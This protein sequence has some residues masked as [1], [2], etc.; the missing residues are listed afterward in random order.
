MI[1][2]TWAVWIPEY[3]C[4]LYRLLLLLFAHLFG[5]MIFAVF[6]QYFFQ[7]SIYF[8]SSKLWC[9]N[10]MVL[11]LIPAVGRTSYLI[12]FFHL[13]NLLYF[14]YRSP[15]HYYYTGGSSLFKVFRLESSSP[16]LLSLRSFPPGRTGRLFPRLKTSKKRPTEHSSSDALIFLSVIFC[17]KPEKTFGMSADGA[18]L[19][20]GISYMDMSAV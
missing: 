7:F 16:F 8:F 10:Y 11:T 15:N 14:E 6:A 9:K 5:R 19:R 17:L 12:I 4:G 2:Y 20:R 13:K 18:N 1:H 3:V